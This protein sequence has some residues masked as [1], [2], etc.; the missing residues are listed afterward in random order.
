[1]VAESLLKH[2]KRRLYGKK[3]ESNCGKEKRK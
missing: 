2:S 1:M 3:E